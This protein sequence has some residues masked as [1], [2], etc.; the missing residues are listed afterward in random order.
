MSKS[1]KELCALVME[2]QEENKC[3]KMVQTFIKSTMKRLE[4]LERIS[5][6]KSQQYARRTCVEITGIPADII[7]NQIENGVIEIY[8]AGDFKV[9]GKS[10]DLFD[11]Q[12]SHRK[13]KKSTEIVKFVNRKFA[14]KGLSKSKELKDQNI[15]GEDSKL[16]ILNTASSTT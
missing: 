11:I 5:F 15:Y 7:A 6:F 1:K 10:L 4:Y 13:R 8:Q 16:L 9:H 14:Y 12:A 3:L 2:M